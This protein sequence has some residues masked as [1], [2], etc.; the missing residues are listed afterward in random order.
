MSPE[1][2]W[3]VHY[4]TA[5]NVSVLPRVERKSKI[6]FAALFVQEF[7][8]KEKNKTLIK[9]LALLMLKLLLLQV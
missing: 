1:S 2:L 5:I 4:E 7:K 6:F 3:T 9:I 8:Q